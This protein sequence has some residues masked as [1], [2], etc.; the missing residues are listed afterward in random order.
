[1]TKQRVKLT[2][3]D[4]EIL[5]SLIDPQNPKNR[6]TQSEAAVVVGYPLYVV[7][8]STKRLLMGKYIRKAENLKK[9]AYYVPH[10]N[11]N[12]AISQVT[13]EFKA[14]FDKRVQL[15][16]DRVAVTY[17]V[18]ADMLREPFTLQPHKSGCSPYFHVLKEGDLQ[19]TRKKD[20][21]YG[22]IDRTPMSK[23]DMRKRDKVLNGSENWDGIYTLDYGRSFRLRYHK[24][25]NHRH[26]YIAPQYN[27]ESLPAELLVSIDAPHDRVTLECYPM[28][29]WL[30]KY[31]G[32]QF[33]RDAA[34]NYIPL[35]KTDP[36][37]DHIQV[38]HQP[39]TDFLNEHVGTF[40]GDGI[41]ADKSKDVLRYE[42]NA[43]RQDYIAALV[44]SPVTRKMAFKH[45]DE[46]KELTGRTNATDRSLD[47]IKESFG[48]EIYSVWLALE[49]VA[50]VQN[51]AVK[52]TSASI[53]AESLIAGHTYDGGMHQ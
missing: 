40:T 17:P 32:W 12:V 33:L 47:D 26:F 5:I 9:G 44:D 11:Y 53:Q 8:R 27:I 15:L 41:R 25:K 10:T 43:N 38:N 35:N 51:A 42:V 16:A 37:K 31:A 1:M 13:D 14:A 34:G 24:T 3:R 28:L 45:E 18:T 30:T 49:E 48:R 46:I 36:S 39:T 4:V 29:D 23:L 19:F 50:H 22:V 7:S 52:A 6:R 20:Y 2:P 21:F